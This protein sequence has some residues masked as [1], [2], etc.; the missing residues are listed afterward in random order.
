MR[1]HTFTIHIANELYYAEYK[2]PLWKYSTVRV[3]G[4]LERCEQAWESKRA[5]SNALTSLKKS[6]L[7]QTLQADMF[8]LHLIWSRE[9]ATQ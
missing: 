4:E 3:I 6:S 1:K 2:V 5:I 8:Y 7:K 9:S